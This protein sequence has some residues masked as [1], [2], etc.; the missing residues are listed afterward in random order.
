MRRRKKDSSIYRQSWDE[1]LGALLFGAKLN[2]PTLELPGRSYVGAWR[3][4]SV[5]ISF[6]PQIYDIDL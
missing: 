2:P 1:Y 3:G 6:A 4:Y 5:K